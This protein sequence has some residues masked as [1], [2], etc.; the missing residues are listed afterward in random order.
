[1]RMLVPP[2]FYKR[3]PIFERQI[4]I[5]SRAKLDQA[6]AALSK[7][8]EESRKNAQLGDAILERAMTATAMLARSGR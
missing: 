7:A 1:M 8:Q 2:I 4:V 5:W 6:S 3:I